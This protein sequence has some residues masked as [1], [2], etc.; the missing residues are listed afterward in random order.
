M[1]ELKKLQLKRKDFSFLFI[2]TDVVIKMKDGTEKYFEYMTP[3][4]SEEASIEYISKQD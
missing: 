3:Q 2:C 1:K 4:E